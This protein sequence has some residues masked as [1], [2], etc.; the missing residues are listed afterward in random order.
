M[1]VSI[2]IFTSFNPSSDL[3]FIYCNND[4]H[5]YNSIR[6]T[7][8]PTDI[9][10]LYTLSSSARKEKYIIRF[11][12]ENKDRIM[13]V[14]SLRKTIFETIQCKV[15]KDTRVDYNITSTSDIK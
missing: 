1:L 2:S 12:N 14:V 7:I 4:A 11:S 9:V 15:R 6:K 10:S 5:L 3:L 8:R 13:L